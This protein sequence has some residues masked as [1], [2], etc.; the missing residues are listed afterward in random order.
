MLQANFTYCFCRPV[1]NGMAD[2][3]NFDDYSALAPLV[4]EFELSENEQLM[5]AGL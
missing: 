3:S 2:H 1:V 5:F 4:H